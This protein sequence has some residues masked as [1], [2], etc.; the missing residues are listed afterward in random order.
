MLKFNNH[1]RILIAVIFALTAARASR[2]LAVPTGRVVLAEG[3]T[4]E[5]LARTYFCHEDFASIIGS[6]NG[7]TDRQSSIKKKEIRLPSPEEVVASI[8]LPADVDAQALVDLFV[9]WQKLYFT[10]PTL[11][12]GRELT[13]E[14]GHTH[15]SPYR[16]RLELWTL[17]KE[18]VALAKIT[19]LSGQR[20]QDDLC[21]ESKRPGPRPKRTCEI[22]GRFLEYQTNLKDSITGASG[23]RPMANLGFKFIYTEG[24]PQ[25]ASFLRMR[26]A[27]IPSSGKLPER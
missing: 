26:L 20:V 25:W 4:L 19:Q 8:R 21:N 3:K 22:L 14:E 13:P 24:L 16:N 5:E 11:T 15:S 12:K 17:P 2:L 6:L 7:I 10:D 9:A 23:D 18:V 27:K 1:F